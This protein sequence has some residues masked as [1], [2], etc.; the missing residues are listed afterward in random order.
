MASV[1]LSRDLKLIVF[2]L[3]VQVHELA[4]EVQI[5]VSHVVVGVDGAVLLAV[6]VAEADADGL[7]DLDDVG[8]VL[9]GVGVASDCQ[10]RLHAHRPVFQQRRHVA[11]APRPAVRP[12][13]HWFVC[14]ILE[15]RDEPVKYVVVGVCYLYL[16]CLTFKL[17][18]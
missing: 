11:R 1:G 12:P 18:A 13:H 2:E 17:I 4:D 15:R 8:L 10:V 16:T 5:L 3:R 9:P 7:V 14:C 6:E